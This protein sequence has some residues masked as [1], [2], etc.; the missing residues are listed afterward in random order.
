MDKPEVRGQ[1]SGVYIFQQRID[2]ALVKRQ[3]EDYCR[4]T[5]GRAMQRIVKNEWTFGR[6]YFEDMGADFNI[7]E[8][9]AYVKIEAPGN[10]EQ[11]AEVASRA[12]AS[13]FNWKHPLI[14]CTYIDGVENG[15]KFA[16]VWRAHHA[17]ADGQGFTRA[18]LTYIASID[19]TTG[20]SSAD[21][22]AATDRLKAMQH[23]AGRRKSIVATVKSQSEQARDYVIQMALLA[24]GI[25]LYVLNMIW[26][27][28]GAT[29]LQGRKSLWNPDPKKRAGTVEK[30][31]G[32]TSNMSLSEV[33]RVKTILG[34]TVND[35]L[36]AAVAGGLQKYCREK[37]Q[38]K[39]RNFVMLI[40]TSLRRSNDFAVSNESAGYMLTL[41]VD[42]EDPVKRVK[43]I[44]SRM[45]LLKKSWEPVGVYFGGKYGL[46]FP[47][48]Y[49]KDWI[50]ANVG[51]M[52]GG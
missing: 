47:W 50:Y 32:W 38:L 30:Q 13:G 9:F 37:G 8:L 11:I 48:L 14:H 51:K 25:V 18:L 22:K 36:L 2:P 1:V 44:A 12:Q 6:P 43:V 35:L 17:M 10:D 34:C 40:P 41:P 5:G 33:K 23:K 45:D 46:T 20:L 21:N 7:D 27:A 3:V 15:T 31:V 28:V 29:G 4:K 39:D 16:L 19:P 24:F 52:H 26:V 49:R 42:I